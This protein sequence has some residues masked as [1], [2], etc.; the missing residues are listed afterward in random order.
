MY[1]LF[2]HLLT[3]RM[4][5]TINC[6]YIYIYFK[7]QLVSNQQNAVE[8]T[9]MPAHQIYSKPKKIFLRFITVRLQEIVWIKDLGGILDRKL[10]LLPRKENISGT[11]RFFKNRKP[12]YYCITFVR[13]ILEYCSAL[14]RLHYCIHAQNISRGTS[15]GE[16]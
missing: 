9:Q 10:T 5:I 2:S 16:Y 11:A 1:D 4:S 3:N 7:H 13:S 12:R 8:F 15:V 14:L 6:T